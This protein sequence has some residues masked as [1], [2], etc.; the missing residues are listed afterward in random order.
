M[1]AFLGGLFGGIW[2]AL[3]SF[4]S[5][6][7]VRADEQELG[8][9]EQAVADEA[10]QVVAATADEKQVAA[11]VQSENASLAHSVADPASLRLPDSDSRD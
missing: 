3:G 9:K 11:T 4:V 8:Q 10:Q 6:L 5:G 2:S 1:L 7:F